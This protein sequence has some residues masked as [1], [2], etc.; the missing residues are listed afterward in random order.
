MPRRRIR[1]RI[2]L[3]LAIAALLVTIVAYVFGLAR[4]Q[5]AGSTLFGAQDLYI[6]RAIDVLIALWCLWVG[7]SI[8]SFLNV[9][10]WR[11][12]R[13]ESIN[14]RSHCPRCL[15]QLR[16]RDN[17]PVF[18]WLALGGRC[19]SCHLPISPRYP[20]VEATV[21]LDDHAGRHWTALPAELA[22]ASGSLAR[23]PAVGASRRSSG[24]VHAAIPRRGFDPLLGD[25][26]DPYGRSSLATAAGDIC[27]VG[28]RRPHVDLP[29]T[30]GRAMA[31]GGGSD[32]ACRRLVRGRID[33]RPLGTCRGNVS[34][35]MS[36]TRYLSG[37]RP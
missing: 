29:H 1:V 11:M 5:A 14:G 24:F 20:I 36:G 37:S 19:R 25:G 30:D 22:A 13:G 27:D 18:G 16:A 17:F 12:P 4:F 10:A 31:D 3:L 6:P 35:P 9:V 21:G 26:S 7:A 32:L 15:A 23:R 33:S 34:G 28:N 2:P 8:G